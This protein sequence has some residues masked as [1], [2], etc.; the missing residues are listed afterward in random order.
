MAK[1]NRS[2]NH[3]SYEGE[4]GLRSSALGA[5][6]VRR[7]REYWGYDPKVLIVCLSGL[8]PP[9]RPVGVPFGRSGCG[10]VI[11]YLGY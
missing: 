2:V 4:S 8:S 11:C 5:C 9:D 6:S 7:Y 1:L 3:N 10:S